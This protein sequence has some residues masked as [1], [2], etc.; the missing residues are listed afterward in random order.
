M[1]VPEMQHWKDKDWDVDYII[2]QS[3]KWHISSFNGKSSAVPEQWRPHVDRWLTKM[4][5]RFVLWKFTAPP[6]VPPFGKLAFTTWW[7]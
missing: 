1:P 3:L 2:D 7:E 6:V 4:G 5:Y